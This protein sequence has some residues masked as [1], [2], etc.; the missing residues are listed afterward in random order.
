MSGGGPGTSCTNATPNA[1]ERS[2]VNQLWANGLAAAM[3]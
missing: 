2:R 3:R 1:A